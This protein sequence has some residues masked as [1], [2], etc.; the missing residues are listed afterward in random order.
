MEPRHYIILLTTHL[1]ADLSST[2][3]SV[4]DIEPPIQGLHTCAY[5]LAIVLS[6]DWLNPLTS[7]A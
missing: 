5:P 2:A 1:D 4:L 7:F 6:S 3:L